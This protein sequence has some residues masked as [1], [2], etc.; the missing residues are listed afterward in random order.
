MAVLA[1][2]LVY[3]LTGGNVHIANII[4]KLNKVT[5]HNCVSTLHSAYVLLYRY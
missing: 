5:K 1:I 4:Y 3:P 2:N